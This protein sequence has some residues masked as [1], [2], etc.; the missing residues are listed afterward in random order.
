MNLF[1]VSWAATSWCSDFVLLSCCTWT[2]GTKGVVKI[3]RFLILFSLP[4]PFTLWSVSL[5]PFCSNTWAKTRSG[6]GVLQS[7]V[8]S[9]PPNPNFLQQ[10][11]FLLPLLLFSIAAIF[12]AALIIVSLFPYKV[13]GASAEHYHVKKFCLSGKQEKIN[14]WIKAALNR[15]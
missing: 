9:Q 7:L 15:R 3:K 5:I 8:T 10:L 12:F 1:P 6:N 4:T 14:R 13:H 11:R 2:F